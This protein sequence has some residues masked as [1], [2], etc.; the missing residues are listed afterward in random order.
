MRIAVIGAG[1]VGASV[2]RE[3]ATRGADRTEVTVFEQWHPG[4]GTSASTFAW[5]NSNE[6]RP[7]SYHRLNVAGCEEHRR[8]ATDLAG[9][10]RWY[11]PTG[12]LAWACDPGDRTEL[13]DRV[14]RLDRLGYPYR[15]IEPA[16]LTD[17]EPDIRPPNAVDRVAFFPSEGYVQPALLLARLLGEAVDRGVRLRHPVTVRALEPRANGVDVV[18]A[19]AERLRF[20]RVVCCAGRS[21]EGLAATVGARIPLHHDGAAGS[22][23]ADSRPAGSGHGGASAGLLATTDP[24]PARLSRV[25]TTPELNVRPD[26]GGRLLMHAPDL[27]T[28]VEADPAELAERH[29]DGDVARLLRDRLAKRLARTGDAAIATLRFGRRVLPAD[30]LTVAGFADPNTRRCYVVATHSGV[31]L[32]PLLGRLTAGEVLDSTEAPQLAG[33]R[34]D[35]FDTAAGS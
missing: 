29:G 5:V 8:L 12:N 33:Y 23:V 26:G 21:T 18:L 2:A 35:R 13:E 1:V 28:A 25:L 20:D 32:G 27:D 6:K 15:W 22:G 19:D 34:P 24:V 4:S 11:F 14:A 30:G 7:D 17:L 9:T 16:E 31:T 10:P 3:L